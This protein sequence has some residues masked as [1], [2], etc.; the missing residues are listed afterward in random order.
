[1]KKI[2][3]QGYELLGPGSYIINGRNVIVAYKKE[4]DVVWVKRMVQEKHIGDEEYVIGSINSCLL[5]DHQALD[6]TTFSTE[7]QTGR[8]LV[9]A[10]IRGFRVHEGRIKGVRDLPNG[11][12]EKVLK[13]IEDAR[14][15]A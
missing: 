5:Q 1:M 15:S 8:F 12:L 11:D 2:D 3:F 10:A 14:V 7:I 4:R 6:P 13:M 9:I